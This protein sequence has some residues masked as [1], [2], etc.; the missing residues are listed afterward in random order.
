ME[1]WMVLEAG[2]EPRKGTDIVLSERCLHT[3]DAG[4]WAAKGD[5]QMHSLK[6]VE[7]S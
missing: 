7:L 2:L 6:D 4:R 5:G 1:A 3:W